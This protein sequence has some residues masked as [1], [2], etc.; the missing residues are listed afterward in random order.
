M[1]RPRVQPLEQAEDTAARDRLVCIQRH[2]P[3]PRPQGIPAVVKALSPAAQ[4]TGI[5]TDAEGR[6]SGSWGLIELFRAR[7]AFRLVAK[8]FGAFGQVSVGGDLRHLLQRLDQFGSRLC[9]FVPFQEQ[10]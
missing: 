7:L 1:R 4:D 5:A 9:A 8:C 6:T 3:R 2:P 10:V